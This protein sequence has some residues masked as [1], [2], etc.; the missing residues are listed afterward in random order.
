VNQPDERHLPPDLSFRSA[1]APGLDEDDLFAAIL[2]L[3]GTGALWGDGRPAPR[4][5]DG[6]W[7]EERERRQRH[8]QILRRWDSPSP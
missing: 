3:P 5:D 7:D 4:C 6:A 2:G 1:S 8:E